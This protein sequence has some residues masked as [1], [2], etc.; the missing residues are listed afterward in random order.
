MLA[1]SIL[2]MSLAEACRDGTI[3]REKAEE[4]VRRIQF[5]ED[6]PFGSLD[7]QDTNGETALRWACTHGRE[8]LI[9]LFLEAGADPTRA[10]D[11]LQ[12]PLHALAW[13]QVSHCL[14]LIL[15]ADV[16]VEAKDKDGCTAL[17]KVGVL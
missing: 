16:D 4:I 12:T 14:P 2:W 1:R 3:S 17:H 10:N 6:N 11:M 9:S 13:N 5:E 8:D 15:E 7:D